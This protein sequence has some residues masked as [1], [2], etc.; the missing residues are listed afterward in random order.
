MHPQPALAD[1]ESIREKTDQ[2]LVER[3]KAAFWVILLALGLYALRDVRLMWAEVPQLYMIKLIEIAALVAVRLRL[4][5]PRIWPR[6]VPLAVLTVSSIYVMTAAS[7]ILR[8]DITSTPLAFTVMA[9]ASAALLPWGVR[10]QLASVVVAGAVLLWNMYTVTGSHTATF[11]YPAVA[12][13]V[14]LI[15]SL[16]VAYELQRYRIAIEERT[17]ALHAS[18]ELLRQSEQHFRSLIEQGRDL[19]TVVDV[20]GT[21]RY[22]SPSITRI[23]GY[24]A[25]DLVGTNIFGLIHTDD[26]AEALTGFM[27]RVTHVGDEE[28]LLIRVRHTNG[29]WRLM[30]TL[31]STLPEGSSLGPVVINS[32]DVTERQQA[33][34]ALRQSEERYRELL[35]NA[36]DMVYTHDLEGHFTSMNAAAERLIGYT[37]AEA[38]ARSIADIVAPEHL[39]TAMQAAFRQL[40]GESLPPYE[41]DIITKD[42]RRLPVEVNTRLI[43]RDGVPVG[44]QGIARDVTA[45]KRV[46]AQLQQAKD[47]AEAAN[48]AKSEFLA[49]VSHEIRTPMNGILGMT[50]LALHTDL[51]SEQRECLDMVKE[52]ADYLLSVINDILDFSK[53]EAGKLDLDP[54]DFRLSQMLDDTLKP[55]AVRASQKGLRLTSSV[56][57]ALPNL[58]VGDDGRLRQVLVNLVGNAIKFTEAGDVM[59]EVGFAE[60]D[61][62]TAECGEGQPGMRIPQS[63][64]DLHFSVRDSGVGIP[65]QKQELIFG[66]FAQADGSMA[67]RYGGTGLG[68]TISSQLVELMGGRM[69]VESTVGCGSTFH[70]TVRLRAQTPNAHDVPPELSY[71]R[72]LRVLVVDADNA[73]GRVLVDMLRMW[74]MDPTAL[75][76]GP[77]APPLMQRASDEG[78]PFAVALIAVDQP[79]LDGVALIKQIQQHPTISAITLMALTSEERVGDAGRCQHFGVAACLRRPAQ[80]EELLRAFLL[81]LGAPPDQSAETHAAVGVAEPATRSVPLQHDERRLHILLAEDNAV[82]QKLAVRLL[83]KRGHCVVVAPNGARAVALWE[84]QPFDVVL[85]DVQM[86]EM[87]G[88]EATAVIREREQRSGAHVPIIAM[89][90]HAMKGDEARCLAAGMDGYVSKPV[91]AGKLLAIIEGATGDSAAAVGDGSV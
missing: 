22:Q 85:M 55:L 4:R 79:G 59:V 33:E 64:V 38:C 18:E 27:R 6:A 90:A 17:L 75:D 9:I 71:L 47:A 23:T 63:A 89:T 91:D 12:M 87:D 45:R 53:V 74:Q 13:A 43:H 26:H 42:G 14:A 35:E 30:E 21:I 10:A 8:H 34:V 36:T 84:Q 49:N 69:W 15:A 86:P 78:A 72:G 77:A 39:E 3:L 28:P 24:G 76:H 19:I 62:P 88:F 25:E 70:F 61:M 31:A 20:D 58:L 41:L 50:E 48:R 46:E 81:A 2:L 57:P 68:L 7:A 83:E 80:R 65:P 29:S 16:Y 73:N 54:I 82:N 66:A 32:R 1:R 52:S 11:G 44:V 51:S 5:D 37:R 56:N 60:C 67:R 40:A